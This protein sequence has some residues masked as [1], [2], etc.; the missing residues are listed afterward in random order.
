MS[1]NLLRYCLVGLIQLYRWLLSP[2][3]GAFFGPL[4]HCRFT[5]SCSEYA[6]TAVQQN[7]PLR[8][9]WLALRRLGRCHPWGGCGMDPVPAPNQSTDFQL[10][11]DFPGPE[12]PPR[13][14]SGSP[15]SPAPSPEA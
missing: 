8:G 7:G 11:F 13:C 3:K 12:H 5:P 10:T 14:A 9:G 4:A 2:L 1:V 6:L 15:F